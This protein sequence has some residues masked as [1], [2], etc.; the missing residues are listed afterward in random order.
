MTLTRRDLAAT[1]LTG[2]VVLTFA[3]A[4]KGWDVWLVGDS[5]RWATAVI[6]VLGVATCALGSPPE[7]ANAKMLATLGVLALVLGVLALVTGSLTALS[8]LVLD[9]VVLW[10]ASTFRHV[11]HHRHTPVAA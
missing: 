11:R 1:V 6:L 9:I 3:A 8:F 10:A 5:Y 4:H 7:G 2:L